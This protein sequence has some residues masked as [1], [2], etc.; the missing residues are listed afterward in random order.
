[1]KKM[2][3]FII[4]TFL[5]IIN[6]F[7]EEEIVNSANSN[8]KS[9]YISSI[10]NKSI[11]Q[12]YNYISDIYRD[13][14][15][16]VFK[17]KGYD[18]S[19]DFQFEDERNSKQDDFD[20]FLKK[21]FDSNIQ[22]YIEGFY[23]IFND[24]VNISIK[25][26]Q[27]D[28][29]LPVS[30]SSI[31]YSY[32]E[33]HIT[34]VRD[35]INQLLNDYNHNDLPNID[36]ETNIDQRELDRKVRKKLSRKIV[37]FKDNYYLWTELAFDYMGIFYLP[38]EEKE[39]YGFSVQAP[40]NRYT[41]SFSPYFNIE[42]MKNFKFDM[43]GF[44]FSMRVPIFIEEKH[45]HSYMLFELSYQYAIEGIHLIKGGVSFFTFMQRFF[46]RD[47]VDNIDNYSLSLM[48]MGL[49]LIYRYMPRRYPF[50]AEIG[51]VI[52]PPFLPLDSEGYKGDS[53]GMSLFQLNANN[54]INNSNIFFPLEFRSAIT[55][56][57]NDDLGIS[58]KYNVS[59]FRLDTTSKIRVWSEHGDKD[60]SIYIGTH[61]GFI[62][63]IILAVVYRNFIQ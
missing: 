59:G 29:S 53:G 16:T 42:F 13:I 20:L 58:L 26:Y 47:G 50:S 57:F 19:Q 45:L 39:Q 49:H 63:R 9:I 21:L 18:I 51:V 48:S 6:I 36:S 17:S 61:T 62:N 54:T 33:D 31:N 27:T 23:Y 12:D 14:I 15:K 46:P 32:F 55:Y 37:G 41:N 30:T 60:K 3:I 25:L 56:F 11:N 43:M 44:G 40:M 34:L 24:D 2:M 7:A 8:N 5:V 28:S 22:F 10:S 52:Y 1:M 4:Y 38:Y 35:L